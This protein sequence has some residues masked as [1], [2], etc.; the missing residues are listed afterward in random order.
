MTSNRLLRIISARW[1]LFAI[2]IIGT[3]VLAANLVGARNRAILPSEATVGITFNRLV[4]EVDDTL[5]QERLDL[6]GQVAVD[7]NKSFVETGI[8]P[9][10]P[11]ARAEISEDPQ[12]GRLLFI[13]RGSTEA[14]AAEVAIAMRSRFLAAQALDDSESIDGRIAVVAAELDTV[15]EEIAVRTELPPVSEAE[16]AASRSDHATAVGIGR[17]H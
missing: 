10:T 3:V 7:V 8:D 1:W 13:G 14:D 4:D 16:L 12:S 9:L 6:A 5:L 15:I 2:I 11:T 17:S